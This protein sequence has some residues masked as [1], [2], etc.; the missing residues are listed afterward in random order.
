MM[1]HNPIETIFALCM[2]SLYPGLYWF[3]GR[4]TW[5]GLRGQKTRT[6]FGFRTGWIARLYGVFYLLIL[7]VMTAPLPFWWQSLKDLSPAELAGS[8][9]IR[10]P[11]CL[12]PGYLFL[13]LGLLFYLFVWGIFKLVQK[14]N[15]DWSKRIK[16]PAW[17]RFYLWS[18]PSLL[19]LFGMLLTLGTPIALA[20][21]FVVIWT[22]VAVWG[23]EFILP[24]EVTPG[25]G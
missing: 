16:N 19:V 7:L 14:R 2:L 4:Y 5:R 18:V 11:G 21:G 12:G 23:E 17:F 6:H 1:N 13:S 24:N 8:L 3:L 9:T 20:L 22:Y 15:P 10:F 25:S